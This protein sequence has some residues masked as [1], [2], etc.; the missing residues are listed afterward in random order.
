MRKMERL[1]HA[2]NTSLPFR[3]WPALQRIG[4]RVASGFLLAAGGCYRQLGG[5]IEVRI[6]PQSRYFEDNYE[7]ESMRVIGN[8]LQRG[9]TAVDVGANIG[10]YS[11][12]MGKRVGETGKIYAFEPS[13]ESF[14]QFQINMELN[15]L[16]KVVEAYPVLVGCEAKRQ[17]FYEDGFQ[18]TNRVGGSRYDGPQTRVVERDTVLLDDFFGHRQRRPKVMKIDVEGY[19]LQVLRG[20][21]ETLRASQCVVLV[22][23]HPDLWP[24]LGYDWMDIETYL[25]EVGF[26]MFSLDGVAFTDDKRLERILLVLRPGVK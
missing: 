3:N 25:E 24:E 5:Q 1:I 11:L 2:L 9:D 4:S 10:L 21:R 6:T 19:E 20:A 8:Q 18:G 7:M 17:L 22:E 13:R 12:L 23:M 14:A 16:G 26:G 15:G